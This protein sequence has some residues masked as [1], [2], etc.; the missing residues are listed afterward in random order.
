M[1]ASSILSVFTVSRYDKRKMFITFLAIMIALIIDVSISGKIM[2]FWGISLFIAIS[3]VYLVGQQLII[4]MVK[5][6]NKEN[7]ISS[8]N[9]KTFD[10]AATISQY[11]IIAIM[12]FVNCK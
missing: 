2:T 1:P 6:K 12:L 10:K 7:S 5:T 4:G 9:V 11:V 8:Y 3:A